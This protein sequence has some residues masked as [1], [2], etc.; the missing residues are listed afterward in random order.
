MKATFDLSDQK[1]RLEELDRELSDPSVW[2]NPTH[3]AE[4]GRQRETHQATVLCIS[5]AQSAISDAQEWLDLAHQDD[6]HECLFQS[7][8][9]A[10]LATLA[11]DCLE[12]EA[13][14]S[15][16]LDEGACFVEIQSGAGGL[17][18]QYWAKVVLR[19]Y[20][21]FCASRGWS[22]E[23]MDVVPGPQASGIRSASFR[24]DGHLAYGWL[25]TESGVHRFLRPSPFDPNQRRHTS[26]CAVVVRPVL[27][28]DEAPMISKSDLRVDVF[29]SSGAGGQH[30]N[31]TES[32]VRITHLPTNTVAA[33]QIHK[34]QQQNR[35]AAMAMLHAKMLYDENQRRATINA[36]AEAKKP[37][38]SWGQQIRTYAIDQGRI[39]DA[40]TG[41]ESANVDDVLNGGLDAFIRES[42]NAGLGRSS[43]R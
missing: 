40:R 22:T 39:K 20:L 18:A 19:M 30:V 42:L 14:P 8:H 37:D 25:K 17:E 32:A 41:L 21:R 4:L 1:D 33:C 29:R 9:H 31:K 3:A 16:P 28:P 10:S 12:R 26:F 7:A 15:D 13:V 38:I 23:L 2:A 27:P 11:I 34:S 6:D 35:V 5:N 36:E 24:V 43:T